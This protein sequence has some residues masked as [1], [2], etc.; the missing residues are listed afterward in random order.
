MLESC[1]CYAIHLLRNLCRAGDTEWGVRGFTDD[2]YTPR[3]G[4][5]SGGSAGLSLAT[6]NNPQ[7]GGRVTLRFFG[8]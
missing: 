2:V 4:G 3:V 6:V 5:V 1:K 7:F 8:D